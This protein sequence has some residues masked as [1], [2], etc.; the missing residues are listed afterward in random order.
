MN[1]NVVKDAVNEY[2]KNTKYRL[3]ITCKNLIE[4]IHIGSGHKVS[5]FCDSI[6]VITD[7]GVYY[8][9]VSDIVRIIVH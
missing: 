8:Y 2:N 9:D 7:E 4:S 6:K 1:I 5:T 3:R